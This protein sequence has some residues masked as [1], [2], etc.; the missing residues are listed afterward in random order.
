MT[1][2]VEGLA[3]SSFDGFTSELFLTGKLLAVEFCC[4]GFAGGFD[5]TSG[6]LGWR[7]SVWVQPNNPHAKLAAKQSALR[8][9]MIDPFRH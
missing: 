3:S 8:P 1:T 6:S 5:D 4:G 7:T 9:S 2:Q